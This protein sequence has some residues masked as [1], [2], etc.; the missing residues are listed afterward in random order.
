MNI[1][2]VTCHRSHNY[3]AVLQAFALKTY[4]EKEGHNVDFADIL[5][6]Y[7]NIDYKVH[8]KSFRKSTLKEKLLYFKYLYKWWWPKYKLVNNRSRNFRN[9][10]TKYLIKYKKDYNK[11]FFDLLVY[12]SD[13]IWSKEPLDNGTI[14][15]DPIFWGDNTLHATKKITYSASMGVLRILPEDHAFIEEK[16][17]NFEKVAVRELDLYNYLIDNGLINKSKIHFTIDPVFLLE[18]E[19][20]LKLIKRR[21][22]NE[23]YL[24]FYDFQIDDNTTRIVREIAKNKNLKIVRITDGVVTVDKEQGYMPTAGP[25]EFLSLIYYSDFVVSSSF[26]GTAFSIVFKKQFIVRQVW[27]KDR[28]KTLLQRLGLSKRFIDGKELDYNMFSI[29]YDDVNKKLQYIVQ[30]SKEYLNSI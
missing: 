24:L 4:L 9:F 5:P 19:N 26:H 15:F 12:G 27:N 17:Q 11:Q 22:V 3:G 25:L 18:T 13:Q 16:L 23:P 7:F 1:G 6:S 30:Q 10:I 28:V 8:R 21:I 2:I 29:N 20:W 14:Y